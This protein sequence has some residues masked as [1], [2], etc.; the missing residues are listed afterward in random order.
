MFIKMS[1]LLIVGLSCL[2]MLVNAVTP[3]QVVPVEK[4]TLPPLQSLKS[5]PYELPIITWGGTLPLFLP[6]ATMR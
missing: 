3:I 2:P 4:R 6:M 1:H 5:G